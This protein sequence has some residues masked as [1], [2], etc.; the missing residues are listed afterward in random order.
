MRACAAD[1]PNGTNPQNLVNHFRAIILR[2]PVFFCFA[3][4]V[5]LLVF[6][7]NVCACE[8]GSFGRGVSLYKVLKFKNW[9]TFRR[10]IGYS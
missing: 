9:L 10:K 5:F 1:E 6:F 8:L 2:L 7:V 4:D 3:R